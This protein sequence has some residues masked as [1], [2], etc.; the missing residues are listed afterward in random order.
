MSRS[1]DARAWVRQGSGPLP[2]GSRATRRAVARAA[3]LVRRGSVESAMDAAVA[4]YATPPAPMTD[5]AERRR[6][7]VAHVVHVSTYPVFPRDHGGA[8]RAHALALALAEDGF[9]S[10]ILSTT[11][12]L[13]LVGT[14]Q[15]ADNLVEYTVA[16]PDEIE[17]VEAQLRLLS[18]PTAI[19]DIAVG[20]CWSGI[21]S[22][23]SELT[24]HLSDATAVV[25]VQA[26]L[27]GAV[28]TVAPHLPLILDAH[29]DEYTLKSEL[30]GDS[31]GARWL[32]DRVRALESAA[33]ENARLVVASTKADLA[34][35]DRRYIV[36]AISDV[37]PNGVATDTIPF[38][39]GADR[40]ER[41]RALCTLLD[42]PTDKAIAMFVGSSHGPNLEAAQRIVELAG[43]RPTSASFWPAVTPVSSRNVCPPTSGRSARSPRVSSTSSSPAPTSP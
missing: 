6:G 31:A 40:I 32:L 29:N 41:R 3:A 39:V 11:H 15:L 34:S 7:S 4:P 25:A 27:G 19:T 1:D 14:H 24:H 18:G 9:R 33:S 43:R 22:F 28:D 8:I 30:L 20:L 35:L 26:Y 13:S 36:A 16:I 21:D 10:T 37:V 12:D 2:K 5:N 23:V 17:S 42:L 38:V